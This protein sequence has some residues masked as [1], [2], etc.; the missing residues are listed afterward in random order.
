MI[1]T[2]HHGPVTTVIL[3]R[4]GPRNAV[5][6]ATARGSSSG[7]SIWGLVVGGALA[8]SIAGCV[9]RGPARPRLTGTC[10]GACAHYVA[11]KP[12]HSADARG[13]CE[14]ECPQVFAD[15]DSLMEFELLT[16]ADAVEYIDGVEAQTG[17]AP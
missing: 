4:P 13:Q 12:G 15:P 8:A 2:E 11:C 6:R 17:S 7:S 10:Q 1:R 16:C 3:D 9:M 14:A 5:D